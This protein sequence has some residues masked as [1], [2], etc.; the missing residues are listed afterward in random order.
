ML[1]YFKSA[2][3]YFGYL[4]KQAQ[5]AAARLKEKLPK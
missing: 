1:N 4:Q 5:V 3:T 2:E